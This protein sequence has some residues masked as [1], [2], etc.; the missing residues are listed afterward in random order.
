[1]FNLS[2]LLQY[3]DIVIQCH[4]NPDA[5][6]I[7][8]AFGVQK[9]LLK[10]GKNSKII[11][12]GINRI[13]KRNI[14]FMLEWLGI[15]VEHVKNA[16]EF[17]KPQLLICVDCQYA[18]GNVTK[19]DAQTVAV[20]DHHIQAT[21]FGLGIIQPNLGSCAALVW[22][23]MRQENFDFSIDKNLATALYY[24]HLT[25]TNNFSEIKHPFDKDIR[26]NLS[27]YCDTGSV[28]RLSL[29]NLT[30]D[31]L[32][33]AGVALLRNFV[34]PDKR[35]AVFKSEYCDPNILGFISDITLQVD[36][37]DVCVVYSQRENGVKISVRSCSRKVMAS[38]F[39]E[40]ITRGIGSG[41][42]HKEKAGGWIKKAG[43][44]EIGVTVDDYIKSKTAEYFECYDLID[45]SKHNIDTKNMSRYRKKPVVRGFVRTTDVF[46]AQTPLMIRMIEGDSHIKVSPNIYL[47]IGVQGEVYPIK[48]EK[49]NACYKLCDE[50]MNMDD[51]IYTPWAQNEMTGE[52][53]GLLDYMKSCVPIA[54]GSIFVRALERD[55]KIFTDWNSDGYIYGKAE[56]YLAIKC[57]D[58]ND[59]YIVQ[60]DIF[61]KT[62]EKEN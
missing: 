35:Y 23:L 53:K 54:A 11:Y 27:E 43:I 45:A 55:T 50:K 22:S 17:P 48:S 56:D 10:H 1:M 34:N 42:G 13:T 30:V 18:E 4:D 46:E 21:E 15:G 38:E 62:Y 12:S 37:V 31:E 40:F 29:C 28:K 49:F 8:S 19:I 25:D 39:A 36:T 60:K 9:Y 20:I 58:I 6:A 59:V 24:G 47:M 3:D 26:D 2:Q 44:D 14:L 51:N 5:D 32:E 61:A 57:D 16:S 41:G 33:I 52:K 7:S